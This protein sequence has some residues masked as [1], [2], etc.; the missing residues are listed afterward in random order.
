MSNEMILPKPARAAVRTAPTMPRPARKDR[1]FAVKPMAVDQAAVRLHTEQLGVP[2]LR[3]EPP[4]VAAEKR[5]DVGVD[6]RGIAARDQLHQRYHPMADGNLREADLT[7]QL[8]HEFLVL[9]IAI[10]MNE[11]DGRRANPAR[12]RGFQVAP[13]RSQIDGPQHLTLRGHALI[14][15]DQLLVKQLRQLAAAIEQILG[16]SDFPIGEHHRTLS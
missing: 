11:H 10:A 7:R 1:I 6:D 12:I 3:R 14:D 5:R 9:R 2:Q 13:S 4:D 16:G 15:L 8:C